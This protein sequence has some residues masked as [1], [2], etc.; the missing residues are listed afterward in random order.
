MFQ[1]QLMSPEGDGGAGGGSPIDPNK[2]EVER[3]AGATPDT[4]ANGPHKHLNGLT[5]PS[6]RDP[7][8]HSQPEDTPQVEKSSRRFS[9]GL[10]LLAQRIAYKLRDEGLAG[11]IKGFGSWV[12]K[13]YQE[14][15]KPILFSLSSTA[16]SMPVSILT[17]SATLNPLGGF[18]SS[19]AASAASWVWYAPFLLQS[20]FLQD[21]ARIKDED[22]SIDPVKKKNLIKSYINFSWSGELLWHGTYIL[23]QKLLE[24]IFNIP[25]EASTAVTHL[26]SALTFAIILPMLKKGW[27]EVFMEDKK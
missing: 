24:G 14:E 25:P 15:K 2:K 10:H 26:T 5:T 18:W 7:E 6:D 12:K 13:S 3:G 17:R 9:E 22:G 20:Y 4:T 1:D 21:R 27:N 11:V 23:S 19:V 8:I 16:I